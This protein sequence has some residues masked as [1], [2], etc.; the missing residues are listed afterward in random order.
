MSL[1]DDQHD[2]Q[3][4]VYNRMME[5]GWLLDYRFDEERNGFDLD[6]T[7]EGRRA[8][9]MLGKF[10]SAFAPEDVEGKEGEAF[11]LVAFIAT[12]VHPGRGMTGDVTW[13]YERMKEVN[14]LI[15]FRPSVSGARPKLEFS[16]EGQNANRLLHNLFADPV[17][18]RFEDREFV[19]GFHLILRA[20][21][22]WKIQS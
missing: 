8:V 7:S 19:R 15:D 5:T 11:G 3:P 18:D 16:P 21:I 10:L 13:V 6:F 14:W 20:L 9:T 4:L 22:W 17:K 12:L 1:Q 2:Y